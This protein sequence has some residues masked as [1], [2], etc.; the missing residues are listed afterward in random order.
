MTQCDKCG[1][2]LFSS[3]LDKCRNCV[4]EQYEREIDAMVDALGDDELRHLN[5]IH[6]EIRNRII[7]ENE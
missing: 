3:E 4:I 6:T 2:A 5:T 1:E 7:T